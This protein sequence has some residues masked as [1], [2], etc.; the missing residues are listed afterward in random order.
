MPD[1]WFTHPPRCILDERRRY[2][3]DTVTR[4]SGMIPCFMTLSCIVLASCGT[5]DLV[6]DGHSDS[7]PV[8]GNGVLEEGEECEVG[9]EVDCTTTCGSTGRGLCLRDCTLP[10][11][12]DCSPP[13]EICGNGID[14]DCNGEIEVFDVVVHTEELARG[15]SAFPNMMDMTYLPDGSGEFV[16]AA[17]P[18]VGAFDHP[19]PI[20]KL[21]DSGHVRGETSSWSF[22][23]AGGYRVF[24]LPAVAG[25]LDG[26]LVLSMVVKPV[27]SGLDNLVVA[28][29]SGDFAPESDL[30]AVWSPLGLEPAQSA[31]LELEENL[32][33]LTWE[34]DMYGIRSSALVARNLDPS[35]LEMTEEYFFEVEGDIYNSMEVARV[36][37]RTVMCWDMWRSEEIV[38]VAVLD[39]GS[40]HLDFW[41]LSTEGAEAGGCDV[42]ADGDQVVVVWSEAG[43]TMAARLSV[44]GE[45]SIQNTWDLS[46][47]GGVIS[48][49]IE[50]TG[51][52]YHVFLVVR[53]ESDTENRL[54]VLDS[55]FA[56]DGSLIRSHPVDLPDGISWLEDDAWNED[57]FALL[58]VSDGVLQATVL[59]C[60]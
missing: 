46:E 44:S 25:L 4:Y 20:W 37:G 15:I 48:Q 58:L 42:A 2:G 26:R 12:E 55:T 32:L 8:C 17:Q 36:A 31:I 39:D 60:R 30:T 13:H 19:L 38:L 1:L 18:D 40:D 47:F 33:L 3:R 35:S 14:D 52:R 50:Y 7:P 6:G 16:V 41:Q 57:R 49:R 29:L 9:S 5:T 43:T 21:D 10:L 24:A 22:D 28:S 11:P 51:S 59:T 27:D 45:L 54:L 34:Y 56:D 53:G 23:G